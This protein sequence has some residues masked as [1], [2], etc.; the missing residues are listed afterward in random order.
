MR[1]PLKQAIR[2]HVAQ[3]S[4][5]ADQLTALQEIATTAPI[6]RSRRPYRL[7]GALAASLLVATLIFSFFQT[8]GQDNLVDEIAAEVVDNHLHLKPL[9]I[10]SG[11]INDVRDYFTRLDFRPIESRYLQD[12]GLQLMGGRYCSLQGITA[13]QLRFKNLG[14]DDLHTLYQVGYDPA[15]YHGLPLYDEG[16]PPVSTY[17]NGVRVTLWVEKGILFALTED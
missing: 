2:E 6:K 16:E 7:A 13:A 12:I 5:D 3:Q 4:L 10:V 14:G 9:E 15:I 8:G 1:H 11:D 17:V